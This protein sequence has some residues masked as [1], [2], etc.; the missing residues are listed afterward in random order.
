MARLRDSSEFMF[1]SIT[2]LSR[3][4]ELMDMLVDVGNRAGINIRHIRTCVN[5]LL[6]DLPGEWRA[7]QHLLLSLLG[8]QISVLRGLP[9]LEPRLSVG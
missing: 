1:V 4:V 8:S 2:R 5:G 6:R 3:S 9:L 7:H